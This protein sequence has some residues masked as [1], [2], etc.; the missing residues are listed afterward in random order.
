MKI[1]VFSQVYCKC[2]EGGMEHVGVARK[3]AVS[4]VTESQGRTDG[5]TCSCTTSSYLDVRHSYCNS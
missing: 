3:T 4:Q 1:V 2:A 5:D